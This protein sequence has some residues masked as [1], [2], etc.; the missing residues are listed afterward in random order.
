[1]DL[2]CSRYSHA[3]ASG[4][5]LPQGQTSVIA[6]EL[7]RPEHL[8]GSRP[9][10]GDA[11]LQEPPVLK[12]APTQ[13]HLAAAVTL[14]RGHERG[15]Q[16]HRDGLMASGRQG[17]RRVPSPTRVSGKRSQHSIQQRLP[18]EPASRLIPAQGSQCQRRF[19]AIIRIAVTVGQRLQPHRRFPLMALERHCRH[20]GG[21]S[22]EQSAEG[23]AE[24]RLHTSLQ[25]LLDQMEIGWSKALP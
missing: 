17:G 23:T 19:D 25:S 11:A 15:G 5:E 3:L 8:Q 4:P 22:I 13:G 2:A 12:T 20:Q 1:M 14:C 6:G 10:Q 18:V 16:P 21:K 7:F 24:R 9:Q